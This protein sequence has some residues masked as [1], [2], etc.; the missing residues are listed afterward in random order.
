[1]G[2]WVGSDI[3]CYHRRELKDEIISR[4]RSI[5]ITYQCPR[6]RCDALALQTLLYGFADFRQLEAD[7]PS[8]QVKVS[9]DNISIKKLAENQIDNESVKSKATRPIESR[10]KNWQVAVDKLFF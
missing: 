7:R 2:I 4:F 1:M 6:V 9:R 8:Y 5:L 3:I 10:C